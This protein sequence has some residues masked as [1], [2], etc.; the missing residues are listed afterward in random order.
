MVLLPCRSCCQVCWNCLVLS[1]YTVGRI[2]FEAEIQTITPGIID[3]TRECGL[4][5]GIRLRRDFVDVSS[6][7]TL[8][9]ISPLD[10]DDLSNG[11]PKCTDCGQPDGYGPSLISLSFQP[12]ADANNEDPAYSPTV[13]IDAS[14]S[15][16]GRSL[17]DRENNTD[18]SD[19][20][21][22]IGLPS[23][24]EDWQAVGFGDHF[25]DLDI[26]Q[27]RL[28]GSEYVKVG[29]VWRTFKAD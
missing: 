29:T 26:L 20:C 28:N 14:G 8:G 21:V 25:F 15:V 23:G 6:G 11:I 3:Q 12:P 22:K 18:W 10:L 19:L 5:P 4:W 13:T 27:K 24:W 1:E 9:Y 7:M 16:I 17:V 2:I